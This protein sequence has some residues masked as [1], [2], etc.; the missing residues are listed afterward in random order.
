MG[1]WNSLSPL[2]PITN[3]GLDLQHKI[4]A[5]L[6]AYA[7][8]LSMQVNQCS[9]SLPIHYHWGLIW[10]S[11]QT[12]NGVRV[13]AGDRG[14][15]WP[16]HPLGHFHWCQFWFGVRKGMLGA[17]CW[18][19]QQMPV[20]VGLHSLSSPWTGLTVWLGWHIPQAIW[21]QPW[22]LS[23]RESWDSSCWQCLPAY[24]WTLGC[25]IP[26]FCLLWSL[27]HGQQ[28]CCRLRQSVTDQFGHYG[29]WV[30]R[31]APVYMSP[32]MASLSGAIWGTDWA[33]ALSCS[34]QFSHP[35]G[36]LVSQFHSALCRVCGHSRPG[37]YFITGFF[38]F[39]FHL[40]G[41]NHQLGISGPGVAIEIPYGISDVLTDPVEEM[42]FEVLFDL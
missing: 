11:H 6:G 39:V 15:P 17:Y 30:A 4:L 13:K 32:S 16:S 7:G 38:I 31:S 5:K 12:S 9:C 3:P 10:M 37:P 27:C 19:L 35:F 22:H 42:I 29:S 40:T 23:T 8:D 25:S 41:S 33:V 2:I 21:P 18:L 20:G 26:C 36:N 14:D 1:W 24:F 34:S 28:M